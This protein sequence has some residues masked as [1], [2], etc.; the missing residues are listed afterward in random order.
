MAGARRWRA[1]AELRA[2]PRMGRSPARGC[3]P[4]GLSRQQVVL[5]ARNDGADD[6]LVADAGLD[7]PDPCLLTARVQPAMQEL[8]VVPA[9]HRV[10]V[11]GRQEELRCD[12]SPAGAAVQVSDP[13]LDLASARGAS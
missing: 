3:V 4:P 9:D 11:L 1:R 2:D 7:R 12:L 8:R 10:E 5:V 6:G 13:A